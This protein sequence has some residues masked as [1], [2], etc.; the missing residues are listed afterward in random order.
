[1]SESKTKIDLEEK[2][3]LYVNGELTAEEVD[4]LWAELIQDEYYYDYL[5]TVASLKALGEENRK[6]KAPSN[7]YRLHTQTWIA[8]AAVLILSA[9]LTLFTLQ[10]RTVPA[11]QP[12]SSIELDY[13]RS[14]DG[15]AD[16]FSSSELLMQAISLANT[17]DVDGAISFIDDRV[18]SIEDEA[19][20]HELL[21]TA[22]SILYNAGRFHDAAERFEAGLDVD[23]EDPLMLERNYW[24]LGNTYFQLNQI[25]DAKLALQKARE[26]NGAYSRVAESYLKALSD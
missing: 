16:E 5:K 25:D 3:D 24:Y 6:S 11:V 17:G 15:T 4:D 12:V 22:G 18:Q 1:M 23:S 7:V 13:Y 26:L 20:Q 9:G 21:V 19:S 14:A 2:I 8:A 10:D